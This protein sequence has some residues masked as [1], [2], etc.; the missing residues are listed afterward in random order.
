MDEFS[1]AD[2]V[3]PFRN[4]NLC[5]FTY[6]AVFKTF[7]PQK[8]CFRILEFPSLDPHSDEPFVCAK[9]KENCILPYLLDARL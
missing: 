6:D 4:G 7:D 2:F 5:I 3:S 8:K 1:N 9:R